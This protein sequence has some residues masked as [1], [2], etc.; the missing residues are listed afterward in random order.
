MKKIIYLFLVFA[1]IAHFSCKKE[2]KNPNAPT[3]EE[4]FNSAD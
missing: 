3:Q 4:V 1:G 2:Y